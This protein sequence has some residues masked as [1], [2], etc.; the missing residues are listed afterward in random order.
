MVA[1]A[2]C[3]SVVSAAAFAAAAAQQPAAKSDAVTK[4]PTGVD[5]A[6]MDTSVRPGD[7][8]D[9][10]ANGTWRKHAV[11]PA[12]RSSTGIFLQ[13]F[14]KAEKRNAELIRDAAA[15]H[16]APGSNARKIAD[17][18]AAYMDAVA[19]EKAGLGPLKPELDRIAAIKTGA[20]LSRV[21]GGQLRADVDPI[22]ATN[23]HT[24]HLFGLFVTQGL[25]DPSHNV[26]YL[27][28]GGLGMPNREYYLSGDQA[29]VAFRA[30]YL[31][32]IA[33][34]LQQAGE[35]DAQAKAKSIF[36][37]EM[38]IAKAQA[39]LVD[40]ED[41][42]KANN[43][44]PMAA[45]ASKAPGLD[46]SAFFDAAGLA[47]QKTI[48]AW[49]PQ[50]V[51]GLSALVASEPLQTW[52]DYLAFH[53]INHDAGLL[54]KAYAERSFEF[55]GHALQGTPKQRERWKRAISAT[56]ADLGDAVGQI[57]VKHYFPA[58][59]KA[60]VQQ[61]VKN[62]LAA[63]DQR[64]DTLEWMT[65]AT[66][67]KAKA[68]IATIKVGVGYP[69]TWRDYSSLEIRPHDALGNALRA[70]EYEY[71]HQLAKLDQSVD[72]G[73][74]WMTPQTVN[75]VNLPLQNALN[76]PAAIL[77]APFFDPSADAAANYGSIGAVIGH[78]I[79]HSFD[80]TGAEFDAQGRMANWW[81]PEDQ[82]HFKAASQQLVKQYN[83]Y[84]ALPGLHIDGQQTL[85]E[86]IADVSG[87]TIAYLAY[88]K[89]LGGKPAPVINGLSGD[90]RFF[91]AYAQSWREK[92]R[93]AAMRAQVVGNEHAPGRF[94]AQ[95]V[96][97][98]DAWY[99]AFKPAPD[100]KLY[101]DPQQRVKI[102]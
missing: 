64:V 19:I 35:A 88:Q 23:F 89:S 9:S 99:D 67:Q 8:F 21:L 66:K 96:R 2:L 94:R 55:Y 22:N 84:E 87:L 98:I 79:S 37:L 91:L 73:E 45:F 11:I 41:V 53:T 15:S 52:K 42:H 54:P 28:Q 30:K 17:Y 43:L 74:W 82:A 92:T 25:E 93:D 83:A 100:A 33:A 40:S 60:E 77:E 102:W 80:N 97:N 12:D 58:S 85:G 5:R 56:N 26:A 69:E 20:D 48:D 71:H 4:A 1:A 65:P 38:K 46:W 27:L 6:G 47:G 62:I 16:P 24:E 72:R 75:A 18:Y 50:A 76:F 31:A 63:F 68:K 10:Y 61:M 32:Y 90:Q 59:S 51:V 44:W 86:N 70:D 13:V 34:T 95:T 81:T 29:M 78:E 49:Q 7:D 36:D 14:Q 57:Y 39:S 101:L 3:G